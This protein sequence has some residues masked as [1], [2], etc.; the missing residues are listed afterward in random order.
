MATNSKRGESQRMTRGAAKLAKIQLPEYQDSD[1]KEWTWCPLCEGNKRRGFYTTRALKD[2]YAKRH[3][4]HF[5]CGSVPT[6]MEELRTNDFCVTCRF[7]VSDMNEH[8]ATAHVP[9]PDIEDFQESAYNLTSTTL[10][11][12]HGPQADFTPVRTP[13]QTKLDPTPS[14]SSENTQGLEDPVT[15]EEEIYRGVPEYQYNTQERDGK[16]KYLCYGCFLW[17]NTKYEIDRHF[18]LKHLVDEMRWP[19]DFPP[20]FR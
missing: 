12:H 5:D 18:Y 11:L 10:D 20:L 17:Y 15:D 2:H 16:I 7:H 8:Q 6:S 4:M 13:E 1:S 3:N 14:I 9:A 19:E